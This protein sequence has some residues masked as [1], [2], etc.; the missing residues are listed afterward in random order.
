MVN[1][2]IIGHGAREH[3][4]GDALVNNGASLFVYNNPVPFMFQNRQVVCKPSSLVEALYLNATDIPC[5]IS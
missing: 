1:F 3:A 2:L 4:I 5:Y